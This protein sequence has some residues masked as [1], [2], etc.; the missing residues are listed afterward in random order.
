M[1]PG[2]DLERGVVVGA[3]AIVNK[4]AAEYSIIAGCPAKVIGIRVNAK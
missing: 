4:N 3:G 1:L 2:V